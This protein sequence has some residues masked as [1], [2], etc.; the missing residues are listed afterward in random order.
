MFVL[1]PKT[2]VS[3]HKYEMLLHVFNHATIVHRCSADITGMLVC[4]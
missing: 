1:L 4:L 3:I 2:K